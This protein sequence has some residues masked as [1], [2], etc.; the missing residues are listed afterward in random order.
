MEDYDTKYYTGKSC[1]GKYPLSIMIV[2]DSLSQ[3]SPS[4][5]PFPP[6]SLVVGVCSGPLC[7][8]VWLCG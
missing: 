8:C 1:A 2:V 3:P 5:P 6:P 4:I 7:P